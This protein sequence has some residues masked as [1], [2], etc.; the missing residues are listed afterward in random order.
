M[1]KS[2]CINETIHKVK[3]LTRFSFKIGNTTHFEKYESNGFAKQLRMKRVVAFKSFEEIMLKGMD[4][5]KEDENLMFSFAEKMGQNLICH[6]AFEALDTFIRQ[7]G[8]MPKP[9]D[10]EDADKFVNAAEV[11]ATRY[12][13]KV[14]EWKSD[15]IQ[16]KLLF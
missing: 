15:G 7:E 2:D 11:I 8:R 6:I 13:E 3:V 4:T 16:L 1:C 5:F 10:I 14:D 9:W 12:D